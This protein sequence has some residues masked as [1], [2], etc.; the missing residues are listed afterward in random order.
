MGFCNRKALYLGVRNCLGSAVSVFFTGGFFEVLT[1][2]FVFL[3]G[4]AN[5]L[6][7][8]TMRAFPSRANDECVLQSAGAC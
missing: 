5:V 8:I 6:A 3:A 4:L 2:A 7:A 1:P